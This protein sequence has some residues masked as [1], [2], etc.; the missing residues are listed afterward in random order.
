MSH[1]LGQ[2]AV[3]IGAGIGGLS[4]A[5][6]LAGFF[7]QV[8]VLERDHL[9][10]SVRSRAGTPQD[11][12]THGLLAGGLEAIGT[13]FP[14]IE[15]DLESAGAVRV[16]VAQ[17]VCYERADIGVLPQ[18]D[19]GRSLLSATRPL[20]ESV[21]RQRVRTHT[22]ITLHSGARA[23]EIRPAPS[24]GAMA[25]VRFDTEAGHSETLQ[26]DLVVDASGRGGL[27]LS[28]FDAIG[29]N[30]P[31]VSE[32]GIDLRYATVLVQIPPDA[33][34]AWKLA[35]TMPDPPRS[36]SHGVLFPV[37]ENRWTMTI[38]DHGG[39]PIELWEAFLE[40]LRGLATTTMY[41]ALCRADRPS[42]IRHYAFHTSQWRHFERLPRLPLGVLPIADA[43][44]RFNPIHGQGMS[45]AG[46]QARLLQQVLRQAAAQRAPVSSVQAGFMA[47]VAD[48]LQTPWNMSTAADFAFPATRGDR[49]E[50]FED[51][52]LFEAAVFRAAAIDPVVHRCLMDV[53]QLLL[54]DS[55]LQQPDIRRRI[56]AASAKVAA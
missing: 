6:A 11:R 45:S 38:A 9:P 23:T 26:A 44:C 55:A 41:D 18:R 43:I 25:S 19:L 36:A 52:R 8:D 34:G 20:I 5:G 40:A 3:V 47:A 16:K 22:N 2:R 12:H 54:P 33:P 49:P 48:I 53:A 24:T 42:Y 27:T 14:G 4:A 46:Q 30:R 17:D 28:M 7:R 56:D 35:A 10:K 15:G 21:I 13:I 50:N 29:W 32:V 37:E 51:M 39:A 1:L 31:E